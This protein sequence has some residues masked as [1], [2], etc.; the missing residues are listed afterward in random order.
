[1]VRS[2]D[3][4]ASLASRTTDLEAAR[5]DLDGLRAD[6]AALEAANTEEI[7]RNEALNLA[8]AQ[9]RNE[10]DAASETARLAAARREALEALVADLRSENAEQAET[11]STRE[12]ALLAAQSATDEQ[13]A[14]LEALQ[15]ERDRQGEDLTEAE[16]ALAAAEAERLRQVEELT[17]AEAARLAEAAAA[18]ALRKRLAE[19]STELTAMS[20]RLEEERKRAEET[21]T[22]LAAARAARDELAAQQDENLT[23]AQERAALL[24]TA[25]LEL[26]QEQE[27]SADRARQVELLNQQTTALNSQLQN[28]QA[29]LDETRARE[30]AAEIRIESLGSDLNLALAAVASEQRKRADLEEAERRRLEAEAQD[31]ESYRSE[32]FGRVREILG[33]REGVRI[34]GDRFVFFV[35]GPV[36]PGVCVAGSAR[37][38]ATVRCGRGHPGNPGGNTARDQLDTTGGRPHRQHS[39]FRWHLCRQLGTQPGARAF[40]GQIPH[41]RRGHPC[42][43]VCLR[44]DLENISLWTLRIQR[45]PGPATGGSN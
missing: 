30:E 1:M 31:L 19:S 41:Q 24:A 29:L 28:L 9:A 12:L 45:R 23:E 5:E 37:A 3:L 21:L 15:A 14:A 32:F 7:S 43:S 44:T 40:G 27:I 39:H 2:N 25:R 17:E 36:R 42:R 10:I 6:L 38:C 11:L 33:D 22:L 13:R 26:A 4:E 16:A 18:E 20:L 34:V 8:L 35:R